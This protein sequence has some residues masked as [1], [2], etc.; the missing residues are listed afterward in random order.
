MNF[1]PE[2]LAK[3][4]P[5]RVKRWE[6]EYVF[7]TGGSNVMPTATVVL[8]QPR[9]KVRYDS[10]IGNGPVDAIGQAINRVAGQNPEVILF[11]VGNVTHGL[12]SLASVKFAFALNGTQAEGSAEDPDILVASAQAYVKALNKL[13]RMRSST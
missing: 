8:R 12:A 5:K 4:N 10:A 13:L 9:G 11:T 6:L 7:A 1:P 2:S 3:G